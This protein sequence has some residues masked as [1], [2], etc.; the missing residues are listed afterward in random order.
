M[1]RTY[2]SPE[3][4]TKEVFGTFNMA[5]ESN[6]FGAKM[7][8]IEDS[9][10]LNSQSIIWYQMPNGEQ[11]DI[12]V[13]NTLKPETYS[14]ISDKYY[15]QILSLSK[16]QTDYQKE[17]GTNWVLDIN[18]RGM[19]SNYIYAQMKASR[20][21]E[22]IK[23]SMTYQKDINTALKKYIELNVIDRYKATRVDLYIKY[24]DLRSQS[25]LKYNNSWS[26]DIVLENYRMSKFQSENSIDGSYTKITFSQEQPGSTYVFDYYF[27]VL[28][29][30]V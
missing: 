16:T 24:K 30:K 1:R 26:K 7:L 8:E 20:V 27:N 9:I 22:G 18:F 14:A 21:F 6:F 12:S 3:F 5:E 2:I 11:L 15:N 10:Y 28:F 23:S 29:E 19:L 4:E 25:L 13:E 17:N